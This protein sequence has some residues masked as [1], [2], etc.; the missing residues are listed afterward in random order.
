MAAL[1]LAPFRGSRFIAIAAA[2]G[3]AG[4]GLSIA[5]FWLSPALALGGWL[6]A[7]GCA[8]S[9]ALGALIFLMSSHAAGARWPVAVERL[10]VAIIAPLP[11]LALAFVPIAVGAAEL[12]LWADPPHGLPAHLT[13]LLAHKAPY[14]NLPF[15]VVRTIFYFAVWIGVAWWLARWSLGDPKP[16]SGRPRALS[17][18]MLPLIGLTLTFASF[19]WLMSLEPEW[20]SAAYG[21]YYFAGGFV[22]S[23]GVLSALAFVARRAGLVELSPWHFH[24]LGRLLLAFSILWAYIA[25]F[26]A[27]LIQ[28]ANKPEEVT[29]YVHRLEGG[30]QIVTWLVAAGRFAV[31]F[32]LLLPR[33]IKLRPGWVGA[34]G[35]WI[36]VLHY[37]DV[38]WLVAPAI[39]GHGAWPSWLD[40]T[41]LAAVGGLSS[42]YAGWRLRGRRLVPLSDPL[43]AEAIA[44]RSAP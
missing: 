35:A 8:V 18:G 9:I 3:V 22:A 26:Q 20:F 7:F 21:L 40:V 41:A 31:P 37:L 30:W 11:L 42:A 15:F 28:L 36:A 19:D 13:R 24:A 39:D 25:F 44:Y 10:L 32:L 12:Y 17:A 2:V 38:Y 14:L 29:F 23:L 43:L 6:T 27:M 4:L 34:A 33:A 5:G 1:T 16:A